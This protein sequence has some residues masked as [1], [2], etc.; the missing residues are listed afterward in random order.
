MS[1]WQNGMVKNK[2]QLTITKH[3]SGTLDLVNQDKKYHFFY[4]VKI[5]FQ[6]NTYEKTHF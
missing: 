3:K 5:S 2:L 6:T 1:S 4:T